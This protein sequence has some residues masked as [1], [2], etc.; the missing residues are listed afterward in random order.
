MAALPTLASCAPSPPGEIS[1]SDEPTVEL[2]VHNE[3][4]LSLAAYVQWQGGGRPIRLG[5]I[6]A[7]SNAT[8]LPVFRATGLCVMTTSLGN[9]SFGTAV[10]ERAPTGRCQEGIPVERGQRM[11]VVLRRDGQT[12]YLQYD[13]DC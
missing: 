2:V 10:P 13:P 1:P 12:C 5:V 9:T 8:Y 4:A 7:G 6:A 11:D 3:R